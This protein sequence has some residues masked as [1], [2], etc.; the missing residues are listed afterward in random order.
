MQ[1]NSQRWSLIYITHLF[2]NALKIKIRGKHWPFMPILPV[3][4]YFSTPMLHLLCQRCQS[5]NQSQACMHLNIS[6]C[7]LCMKH[8]SSAH[9][10]HYLLLKCQISARLISALRFTGNLLTCRNKILSICEQNLINLVLKAA[11]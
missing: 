6:A 11:D 4:F 3:L 9:L 8:S 1:L 7:L 2:T 5:Q 10:H